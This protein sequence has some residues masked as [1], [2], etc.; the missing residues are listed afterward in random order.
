MSNFAKNTLAL[1]LAGLFGSVYLFGQE[2]KRTEFIPGKQEIFID[3]LKHELLGE[4]PSRWDLRRGSAEIMRFENGNVIGITAGQTDII[5]LMEEKDYLPERFTIELE[6]YFHNYG[7]EGYTIKF[8]DDN[9][10]YFRINVDGISNRDGHVRRPKK[11]PVG[12]RKVEVSFNKRVLKVYYEGERLLNIPNMADRPTR[13]S[14]VALGH[15]ASM[16]KYAMIRNIRI[17]EGGV[18]LYDR[19]IT[20]GKLEMSNIHFDYNEARIKAT[21]LPVIRSIAEMLLEHPDIRISIEGHT[22]SDGEADFNQ[23]LSEQR[24]ESVKAALVDLKV[25]QG[26]LLTKGWGESQPIAD[27]QTDAGKAENRRVTFRML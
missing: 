26:R 8:N 9:R 27:N 23:R 22:D 16:E 21:S 2:R 10:Y 25:L 4:F 1:L 20:D 17:A 19:L 6:V 3:S 5:P 15:G 14:I 7:N 13:M 18:P 24:A 12:W 11:D